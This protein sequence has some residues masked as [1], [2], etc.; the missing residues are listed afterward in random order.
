MCVH[1]AGKQVGVVVLDHF[2]CCCLKLNNQPTNQQ[3]ITRRPYLYTSYVT[4]CAGLLYVLPKACLYAY[5]LRWLPPAALMV[6][7]GTFSW[8]HI[9]AAR[10]V[11]NMGCFNR[12]GCTLTEY[13]DTLCP[14]QTDTG[15]S[16][17]CFNTH[18][19]INT[20]WSV[21]LLPVLYPACRYTVTW[22]R[23]RGQLGLLQGPLLPQQQR[24]AA[25]GGGFRWVGV[26]KRRSLEGWGLETSRLVRQQHCTSKQRS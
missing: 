7:F 12:T 20:V 25:G 8:L 16:T 4:G 13:Q 9:L 15:L 11:R 19:D 5:P 22:Y 14:A 3:S 2:V 10:C 17:S 6:M 1:T 26:F 18:A 23:R 24:T 21:C